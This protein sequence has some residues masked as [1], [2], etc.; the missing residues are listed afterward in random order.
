[1]TTDMPS[2]NRVSL[3]QLITVNFRFSLRFN[4]HS[5]NQD[6]CIKTVPFG[7]EST[8]IT[9]CLGNRCKTLSSLVHIFLS[10]HVQHGRTTTEYECVIITVEFKRIEGQTGN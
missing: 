3:C 10:Y 7:H 8:A 5:D 2:L 1:M 4:L 9:C 6:C